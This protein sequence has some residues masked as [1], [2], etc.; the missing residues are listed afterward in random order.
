[1]PVLGLRQFI[2]DFILLD[3]VFKKLNLNGEKVL[4]DSLL[5]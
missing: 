2:L 1:M 4:I 3:F 5:L